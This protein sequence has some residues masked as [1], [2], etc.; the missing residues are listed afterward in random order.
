MIDE[1]VERVEAG[2]GG[3][4]DVVPPVAD[5]VLLVED[6]SVGTQEAVRVAVRLAHVESLGTGTNKNNFKKLFRFSS[7]FKKLLKIVFFCKV[8]SAV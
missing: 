1:L 8:K 7:T 3:T 2:T 4:V 6:G 5:E